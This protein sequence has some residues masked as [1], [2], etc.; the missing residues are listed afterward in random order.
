MAPPAGHGK[1]KRGGGEA[2]APPSPPA[3][4]KTKA[5]QPHQ[6]QL[7][8]PNAAAALLGPRTSS[9][10][11]E[12]DLA[13]LRREAAA[14]EARLVAKLAAA[15]KAA[16]KVPAYSCAQYSITLEGEELARASKSIDRC[17]IGARARRACLIPTFAPLFLSDQSP[18]GGRDLRARAQ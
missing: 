2:P 15:A 5:A 3:P 12:A 14:A 6:Q 1:A 4:K 11:P 18:L 9:G 17:S 7:P 10:D 16:S 8:F 13:A